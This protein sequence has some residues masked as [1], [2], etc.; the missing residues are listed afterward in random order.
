MEKDDIPPK[1]EEKTREQLQEEAEEREAMQMLDFENK[2]KNTFAFLWGI[3][4]M[5]IVALV[6]FAIVRLWDVFA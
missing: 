6:I 4:I 1:I 5:V 3:T 2:R